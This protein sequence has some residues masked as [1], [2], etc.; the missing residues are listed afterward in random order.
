MDEKQNS[1]N[2]TVHFRQSENETN[3]NQQTQ[4]SQEMDHFYGRRS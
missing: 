1:L 4:A 3:L 2:E